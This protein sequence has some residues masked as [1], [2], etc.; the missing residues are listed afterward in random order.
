M[1][2]TWRQNRDYLQARK[3][4]TNMSINITDE[5][6]SKETLNGIITYDCPMWLLEL[7]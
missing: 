5:F 3:A 6:Q 1:R 7:I 2:W 4:G